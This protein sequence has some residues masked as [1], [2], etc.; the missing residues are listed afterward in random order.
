MTAGRPVLARFFG[1]HDTGSPLMDDGRCFSV[2][3]SWSR[4]V[5]ES[6][7]RAGPRVPCRPSGGDNF[8]QKFVSS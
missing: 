3:E 7:T 5:V 1:E 6:R 8:T 4:G 2:L